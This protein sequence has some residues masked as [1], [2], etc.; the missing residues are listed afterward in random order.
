MR[1]NL[2]DP[3]EFTLENVRKLIASGD[4]SVN[5]QFRV[6][7]DGYLFLSHSVGNR[8][9]E[10]IKFRLETNGAYN[11]YVGEDAAKHEAWVTRIYEVVKKNWPNPI[12]TYIDTF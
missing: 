6:T 3:K 8:D 11:G 5:T 10:G 12:S 9:L 7:N 2:N 1:I 4:D